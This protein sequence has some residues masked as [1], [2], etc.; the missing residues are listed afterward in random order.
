MKS[1]YCS[2]HAGFLIDPNPK[3]LGK[4]F[5]NIKITDRNKALKILKIV[6]FY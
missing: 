2:F 3:L 5:D 6:C 4:S 1:K